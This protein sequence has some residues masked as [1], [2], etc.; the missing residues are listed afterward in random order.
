M[1]Y[2]QLCDRKK[3][4][5]KHEGYHKVKCIS[6]W[7]GYRNKRGDGK[8]TMYPEVHTLASDPLCWSSVEDKSLQTPR[9]PHRILLEP[10]HQ[11]E[12]PRSTMEP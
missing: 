6:K 5:F 4:N 1:Q 7:L 12:N 9:R 8:T 10:S 11:K 2:K 3:Y